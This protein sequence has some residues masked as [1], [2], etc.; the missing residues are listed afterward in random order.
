MGKGCLFF[1]CSYCIFVLTII[2]LSIGPI[3]NNT[4]SQFFKEDFGTLNCKRTKDVWKNAKDVL[5]VRGAFIRYNQLYDYIA[6]S[7]KKGMHFQ[8]YISFIFD[9][10]IGFIC[11][12]LGLFHLYDIKKEFV[13]ITGLIGL[14]CGIVGTVVTCFYVVFNAVVYRIVYVRIDENSIYKRD[15]DYAYAEN[16][17]NNFKCFYY[18]DN[19]NSN[20]KYAFISNLGKK[21]Y[22]YEKKWYKDIEESCKTDKYI[23]YCN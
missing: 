5:K 15:G 19:L 3:I 17:G 12:L 6:C 21:Q 18:D 22:N 1:W 13:P 8:E 20:S 14:I 23:D 10:I 2:N 16:Q 7:F 4:A 11:G 9:L